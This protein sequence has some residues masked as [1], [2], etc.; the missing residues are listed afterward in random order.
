LPD[1][2]PDR[3]PRGVL[4]SGDIDRAAVDRLRF[5]LAFRGYRMDEVD[6]VLDRLVSEVEERDRRIAE[7]EGRGW[8]A[9]PAERRPTEE[10]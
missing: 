1:V 5:T 3:S 6:E 10:R 9:R 8:T 7:L 4:P 2:E